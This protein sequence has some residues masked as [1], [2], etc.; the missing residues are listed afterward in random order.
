M[1]KSLTFKIPELNSMKKYP[2]ELFYI[3]DS[4]LLEKPKVTIVGSRSPNSYAKSFTMQLANK[5][6]QCGICIVSG[7][8]MGI[9]AIAHTNAGFSN[10]I[11]VVANGLDIRYP[12]VNKNIISNIEQNGLVLSQYPQGQKATKY[13]F[14]L[15]N[16]IA[17]SLGN[18]L[19]ITYADINSGSL[20]SAEF[21][22]K[23][24]KQIYVLPHRIGDSDG[25]NSLLEK[26]LAKPIYNIDN[27][28][29]ELGYVNSNIL[30]D[31][32]LIFCSANPTYEETIDKY[33]T[34]IFEYELLGKI[35]VESGIVKLA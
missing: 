30:D 5:L 23:M 3:G 1:V 29:A 7:A 15:R 28:I 17:V 8:A 14:V 18:C 9:D 2:S 35:I 6:S 26:S 32:F 22:L 13:S 4:K 10:T 31:D 24:G 11:A 21:A 19:I 34:K 16:E 20:R 27:F 33:P 12:A 25:T